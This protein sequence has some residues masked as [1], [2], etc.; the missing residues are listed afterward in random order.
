M[1]FRHNTRGAFAFFV[2]FDRNSNVIRV[3]NY[4][5][6]IA[7]FIHGIIHGHLLM[8]LAAH[9]FDVRVAF[10]VFVFIFDV[11]LTHSHVFPVLP[12]LVVPING[13]DHTKDSTHL[14]R[15]S[16]QQ[17]PRKRDRVK[18]GHPNRHD[19][20]EDLTLNNIVGKDRD[21]HELEC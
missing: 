14:Y 11:F 13:C 10:L 18:D 1:P 19:N 20:R 16:K 6:C 3:Y 15:E 2:I 9:P 21:D 4:G 12:L 17:A 8:K 5:I 7:C